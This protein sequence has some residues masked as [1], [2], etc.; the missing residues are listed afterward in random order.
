[1]D[2]VNYCSWLKTNIAFAHLSNMTIRDRR[3]IFT[4]LR[5]ENTVEES[6]CPNIGLFMGEICVFAT[7]CEN[8]R[9]R[10]KT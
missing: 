4:L 8:K 3:L 5:K 10:K 6:F 9:M 2:D 7:L 1:M